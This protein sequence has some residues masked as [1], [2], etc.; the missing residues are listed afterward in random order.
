MLC[1]FVMKDPPGTESTTEQEGDAPVA[2]QTDPEVPNQDEAPE[3]KTD[4]TASEEKKDTEEVDPAVTEPASEDTKDED[5]DTDAIRASPI[6][7]VAEPGDSAED[8]QKKLEQA[9]RC[10]LTT[11]WNSIQNW[12]PMALLAGW[13]LADCNLQVTFCKDLVLVLLPGHCKAGHTS[14]FGSP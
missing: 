14:L 4:D 12:F 6:A 2:E 10:C 5:I 11:E 13:L 7:L 8:I 9:V 3:A 1:L